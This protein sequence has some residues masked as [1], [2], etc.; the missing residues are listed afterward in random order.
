MFLDAQLVVQTSDQI[1]WPLI[2]Y[3]YSRYPPPPPFK[4]LQGGKSQFSS[5]CVFSRLRLLQFGD[6]S[7]LQPFLRLFAWKVAGAEKLQDWKRRRVETFT[8]YKSRLSRALCE[9]LLMRPP[10]SARFPVCDFSPAHCKLYF[11]TKE[12]LQDRKSRMKEKVT[13]PSSIPLSPSLVLKT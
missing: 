6:F 4:N 1:N 9:F 13:D 3:C 10:Q 8:H 11:T 2:R 12:K 5:L 7:S